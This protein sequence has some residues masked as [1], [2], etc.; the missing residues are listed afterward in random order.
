[1]NE[2]EQNLFNKVSHLRV[3]KVVVAYDATM[4]V[5]EFYEK[6]LEERKEAWKQSLANSRKNLTKIARLCSTQ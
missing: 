4:E 3:T 1:M 5:N 2:I 6:A